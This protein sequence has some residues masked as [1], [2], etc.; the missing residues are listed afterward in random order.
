MEQ[1]QQTQDKTWQLGKD[2]NSL[3]AQN[4]MKPVSQVQLKVEIA[5]LEKQGMKRMK[6]K[7]DCAGVN[8]AWVIWEDRTAIQK[9]PPSDWPV[10]KSVRHFLG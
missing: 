7:G 10:G 6:S 9:V 3:V 1:N 4:K 2:Y 8:T 5:K